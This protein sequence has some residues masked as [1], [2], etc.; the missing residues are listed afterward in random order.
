MKT[1]VLI[2]LCL[3]LFALTSTL[4]ADAQVFSSGLPKPTLINLPKASYPKSAK[5]AKLG[6]TITVILQ[7]GADGKVTG[8]DEVLGPGWV[9]PQIQT[10]EVLALRESAKAA[11]LRAKFKPAQLDG[12]SVPSAARV[13]LT[14]G[15]GDSHVAGE[16]VFYKGTVGGKSDDNLVTSS[17]DPDAIVPAQAGPPKTLSGGVLNGKANSLSVPDYPA[18]ARAVRA[19]GAVPVQVLIDTDGTVFSAEAKGGHPLLQSAARNA[20]CKSKFMPTLL[21]GQ[22]VRVSGIITYN[23]VP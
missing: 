11:A 22:P 19:T 3:A 14:F 4:T 13:E 23:F 5:D 6:G 17:K 7:V 21:S 18:V 12:R 15:S 16:D 20:A 2:F 10:P 9:C 1:S 8:I